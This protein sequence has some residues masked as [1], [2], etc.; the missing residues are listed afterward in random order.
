M[1]KR[2]VALLLVLAMLCGLV[3]CKAKIPQSRDIEIV[4]ILGK[5]AN[6]MFPAESTLRDSKLPALLEGAAEYGRESGKCYGKINVRFIVCDGKP[7]EIVL[8]DENGEAL[9]LTVQRKNFDNVENALEDLQKQILKAMQSET[10]MANDAE[11]D[12]IA[13][14]G[15]AGS[16]LQSSDKQNKM[17]V[18]IDNGIST[19]GYLEMQNF[20]I[21][22]RTPDKIVSD[23]A[24]DAK[25]DLNGIA[26]YFIGLGNTDG[27]DQQQL[28]G[29]K[30]KDELVAFWKTYLKDW[31]GAELPYDIHFS[32]D[33]LGTP[34]RHVPG[35]SSGYP[36]VASVAFEDTETYIAPEPDE[37]GAVDKPDEVVLE[38]N[39]VRLKFK[40]KNNN[41][42][43]AEFLNKKSAVT[44]IKNYAGYYEH[45]LKYDP[46]AIFY[47]VG[48]IAQISPDHGKEGGT[49][50]LERAFLVA[51]VM[52]EEAGVPAENIRLIQ[53]GLT[54]LPWCCAE[55][56]PNGEKT[57]ESITTAAQ[58]E[59]R[60][61]AIIPSIFDDKVKQLDA[62]SVETGKK[63]IDMAM[64]YS[65]DMFDYKR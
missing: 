40:P 15:S 19:A 35:D 61:V 3:G 43:M 11:S 58:K 7:E 52:V 22:N 32:G 62:I 23:L 48:S 41:D 4:V 26:V 64:A 45:V 57:P 25:L 59:N 55:E 14:L 8:K 31:C 50:S 28:A 29:Q 1:R 38:F 46:N 60:V 13:A 2:A 18:V 37:N 51:E 65:G 24:K 53:G 27:E 44:T 17:I 39:D 21:Q 6:M 30:M 5:H 9:D 49:T 54:D 36:E 20:S 10:I 42:E 34:L 47:V 33:T 63:L 12:L 56:F 16:M